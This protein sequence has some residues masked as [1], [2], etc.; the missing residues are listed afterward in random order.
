MKAAISFNC[1]KNSDKSEFL[2]SNIIY[3]E[4][5]EEDNEH[6]IGIFSRLG[7]IFIDDGKE[8]PKVPPRMWDLYGEKSEE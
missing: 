1:K 3:T 2:N 5:W 4:K 8:A 6:D 7:E